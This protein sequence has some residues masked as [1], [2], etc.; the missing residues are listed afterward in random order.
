[1]SSSKNLVIVKKLSQHWCIFNFLSNCTF[2][3][4]KLTKKI[5]KLNNHCGCGWDTIVEETRTSGGEHIQSAFLH[6]LR[7]LA[8]PSPYP[9]HCRD[10][11]GKYPLICCAV[12][13]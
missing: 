8:T 7:L 9:I 13:N 12:L 2:D 5:T 10:V 3:I 6:P 4:F 1:M 11:P